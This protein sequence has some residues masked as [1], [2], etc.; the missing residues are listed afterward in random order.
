MA[1]YANNGDDAGHIVAKSMGGTGEEVINLFPQHWHVNQ[2]YYNEF[3]RKIRDRVLEDRSNT[4]HLYIEL[5]YDDT[6]RVSCVC[7]KVDF[8]NL[9]T[10]DNVDDVKAQSDDN[11]D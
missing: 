8:N 2:H 4:A 6:E 5:K 11:P 3:E 7:Y 9:I 10:K 1:G